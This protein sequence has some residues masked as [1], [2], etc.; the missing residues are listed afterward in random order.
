MLL[1]LIRVGFMYCLGDGLFGL[2]Q[3][4]RVTCFFPVCTPWDDEHTWRS[5]IM[6]S[7]VL[8]GWRLFE[9]LCVQ[10]VNGCILY[11]LLLLVLL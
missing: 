7:L 5:L 10:H 8:S 11:W 9:R 3:M 4:S 2:V 1:Q 6:V